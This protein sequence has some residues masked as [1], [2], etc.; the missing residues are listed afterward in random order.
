[1][2]ARQRKPRATRPARKGRAA[3]PARGEHEI[4]LAG[5]TY[6]LRPS[7]AALVEIED[8]LGK[9]MVELARLTNDCILPLPDL[10]E[11]VA[12]LIRAGAAEGD[13]LT[14]NVSGERIAEL[15][16]EDGVRPVYAR[17]TLALLDAITGG[18]RA[19]GEAKAVTAH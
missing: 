3:N 8:T 6:L 2:T 12:I 14:A 11:L 13:A 5:V 4:T 1:M 7:Y 17:A 19:S 9:S 15:A 10:G 16:F 18:R